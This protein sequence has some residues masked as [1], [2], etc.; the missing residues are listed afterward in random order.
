MPAKPCRAS[1]R[2]RRSRRAEASEALHVA[3]TFQAAGKI[4]PDDGLHRRAEGRAE[5]VDAGRVEVGRVGR[6]GDGAAAGGAGRL[7]RR[8]PQGDVTIAPSLAALEDGLCPLYAFGTSTMALF[9]Y[10]SGIVPPPPRPHRYGFRHRTAVDAKAVGSE[11][12][13]RSPDRRR[14][15]TSTPC[16]QAPG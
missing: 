1:W 10:R 5:G 6:R 9:T 4:E 15:P 2:W 12:R 13:R 16:P 7:R 8:A 11:S 3:L 14:G